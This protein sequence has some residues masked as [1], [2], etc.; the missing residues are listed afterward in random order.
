MPSPAVPYPQQMFTCLQF[1]AF[2]SMMLVD[3]LLCSCVVRRV[4]VCVFVYLC[5]VVLLSPLHLL[6][7]PLAVLLLVVCCS[8]ILAIQHFVYSA[9][10]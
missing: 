6:P 5:V 8:V 9:E 3:A 7:L 4:C 2:V 10:L 1:Q